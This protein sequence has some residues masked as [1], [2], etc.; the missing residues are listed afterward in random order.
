MKVKGECTYIISLEGNVRAMTYEEGMT[1]A[2]WFQVE[3]A[4][5]MMDNP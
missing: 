2:T 1:D 5:S 3:I 4:N